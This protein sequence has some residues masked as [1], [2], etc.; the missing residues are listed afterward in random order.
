MHCCN[1][2]IEKFKLN[3]AGLDSWVNQLNALNPIK[4][5]ISAATSTIKV[6]SSCA[7]KTDH[8]YAFPDEMHSHAGPIVVRAAPTTNKY[9]C[10]S[11]FG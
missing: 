11:I 7:S 9:N 1:E 8:A 4:D 3:V 2:Q 5:G 6:L 10:S